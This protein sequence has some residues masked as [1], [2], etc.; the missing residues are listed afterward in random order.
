M[1]H[2]NRLNDT[3]IL[4]F[5]FEFWVWLRSLYR[6][7]RA[8]RTMFWATEECVMSQAT[9]TRRQ[10]M[11]N[12]FCFSPFYTIIFS[13][14]NVSIF[15]IETS[16]RVCWPTSRRLHRIFE[17]YSLR[18]MNLRLVFFLWENVRWV[19]LGDAIATMEN[20]SFICIHANKDC[21]S[22]CVC[23]CSAIG[24]KLTRIRRNFSMNARIIIINRFH[25]THTKSISAVRR[26][27]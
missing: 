17:S 22:G 5:N 18:F 14:A 20:H 1:F 9:A 6:I 27:V 21:F 26:N 15:A 4:K 24:L 23:F 10:L 7:F 16:E 25:W 3:N 2:V 13:M 19:R 12:V 11:R 8:D